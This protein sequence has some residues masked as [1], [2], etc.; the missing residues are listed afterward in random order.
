M[1]PRILQVVFDAHDPF[2]LGEFWCAATGYVRESPPAPHAT[3]EETFVAW[4]LPESEWNAANVIVDPSGKGPRIYIQR[5]PESKSCKNRLHLD[6]RVA[7]DARG[8][9]AMAL[10]EAEA[11]RLTALGAEVAGRVEP[12]EYNGDKGW[13]VMRD[14]EGNEFCLT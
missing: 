12:T 2:T 7:P 8:A 6:V 3:W 10:L 4:G 1:E 14:P 11:E 9:E 5:V 13:I